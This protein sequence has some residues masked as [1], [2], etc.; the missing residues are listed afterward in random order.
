MVAA[1]E[2]IEV[3]RNAFLG[4]G[5]YVVA[6]LILVQQMIARRFT[7]IGIAVACRQRNAVRV[8]SDVGDVA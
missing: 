6:E 8:V 3:S 4:A 5:R 7:G 1:E 2:S